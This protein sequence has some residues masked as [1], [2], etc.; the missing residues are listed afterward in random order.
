LP[1]SQPGISELRPFTQEREFIPDLA[2]SPGSK[3]VHDLPSVLVV[4]DNQL[5]SELILIYL[6]SQCRREMAQNGEAAVRMALN[7]QY[8]IILMDINLGSG[9]DGMEATRQ[10]LKIPGYKDTPIVAVT[11]YTMDS[12]REK[13][14][15]AGCTHYLTKPIDKCELS[16]LI[17]CLVAKS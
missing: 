2:F 10:I 15:A 6:R 3:P 7:K 12:D 4:E 5:N 13:I 17:A 1:S 8:E 11:G 9:I 14:L 16:S